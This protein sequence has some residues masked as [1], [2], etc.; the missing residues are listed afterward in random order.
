MKLF[1]LLLG[2]VSL[3]LGIIGIPLPLLPTVPFLILAAFCFAK[4]NPALERWLLDHPRFG[5]SIRLWREQGAI[6]R[7]GKQ[8]AS[9][10]FVFSICLSFLLLHMPWPLLSVFVAVSALS[11]IWSRPDPVARPMLDSPAAGD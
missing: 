9:I 2:F 3:A 11:W 5:Q 6:S 4:S 10:A 7:V 8:A 1:Y